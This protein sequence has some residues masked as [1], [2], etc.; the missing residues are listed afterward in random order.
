MQNIKSHQ[1]TH[2]QYLK[3]YFKSLPIKILISMLA[4]NLS[5]YQAEV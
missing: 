4:R 5:K 1:F 2:E 3:T